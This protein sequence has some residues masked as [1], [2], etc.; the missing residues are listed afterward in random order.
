MTSKDNNNREIQEGL[1]TKPGQETYQKV[2]T[3]WLIPRN[4]C[5]DENQDE[6]NR[7]SLA[8]Q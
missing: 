2:G 6:E 4:D 7:A 1:E 8:V 5:K 3:G